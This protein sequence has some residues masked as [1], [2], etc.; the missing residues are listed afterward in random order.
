MD[1]IESLRK[2]ANGLNT[3][4]GAYVT[5]DRTVIP[6]EYNEND[7]FEFAR[8]EAST[9]KT[10]LDMRES[11][12][13]LTFDFSSLQD[14]ASFA[15]NVKSEFFQSMTEAPITVHGK[16]STSQKGQDEQASLL[17]TRRLY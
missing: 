14:A 2:L 16:A 1:I 15:G 10:F 12:D 17:P 13:K 3:D 11:T 6:P 7:T 4:K 5:L 9:Y 8:Q